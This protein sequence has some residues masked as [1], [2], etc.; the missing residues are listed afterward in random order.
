V[1]TK[2]LGIGVKTKAWSWFLWSLFLCF[3]LLENQKKERGALKVAIFFLIRFNLKKSFFFC[4]DTKETKD[5][6]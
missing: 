3:F 2:A 4:L 5:Q 6:G 1:D